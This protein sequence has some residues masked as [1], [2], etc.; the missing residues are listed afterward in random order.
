[1]SWPV[2]AC[3]SAAMVSRFFWPTEVMKSGWISTWFLAAKAATCFFMM[4]L[5]AGTQWSQKP[6]ASLPAAW[7]VRICTNGSAVA[8]APSLSALRRVI[9]PAFVPEGFVMVT[10]RHSF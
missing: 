5:P 8:A 2:F 3:A 9:R 10:K 1:M 4:S 7:P 6:T